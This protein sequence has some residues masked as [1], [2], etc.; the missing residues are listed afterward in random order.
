MRVVTVRFILE[1]VCVCTVGVLCL[2]ARRIQ[3]ILCMRVTTDDIYFVLNGGP[4]PPYT[5]TETP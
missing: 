4:D 5:E 2:N 1:V 3:L